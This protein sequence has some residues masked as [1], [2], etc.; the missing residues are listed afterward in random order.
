MRL[1]L[2]YQKTDPNLT[3]IEYACYTIQA[4]EQPG[5]NMGLSGPSARYIHVLLGHVDLL[6]AYTNLQS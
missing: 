4:R 3:Q 1:K 2:E 6:L 5:M